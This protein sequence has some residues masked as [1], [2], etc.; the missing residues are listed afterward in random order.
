MVIQAGPRALAHI[1]KNGLSPNDVAAIFGAAGG[2]KWLSIVGLD[3][4]V[5]TQ[6]MAGRTKQ[7]PV[8]LYGTSI[9]AYK[10]AATARKNAADALTTLAENYLIQSFADGLGLEVFVSNA[11]KI[12]NQVLGGEEGISEIINNP[13]YHLHIGASRCHGF[14]NSS[15]QH[16]QTLSMTAAGLKAIFSA[17]HLVGHADR[18][19]FSDTRSKHEFEARDGFPILHKALTADSLPDAMSASAAVP[20]YMRGIRF[21]DDPGHLYRDGG[22]IDYHPVPGAFW[23]QSDGLIL[24]PHFF[25]YCKLRWFDKFLPSWRRAPTRL[26][27]N[28]VLVSPSR[29]YVASLPDAHLPT[30]RGFVKYLHNEEVRFDKWRT[31]VTRSNELGSL[32]VDA[33]ESGDIAAQIKP[34]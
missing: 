13:R 2:A 29:A 11:A 4:A 6:F 34:L 3:L 20:V 27:D 8:D 5:F 19:V 33:Y 32:F 23:P 1:Q 28:V 30:S 12:R 9:G 25:E 14:L 24:Y 21:A 31:I 26:L 7:T 10:L 17:R 15:N 16:L 22:L 18:V